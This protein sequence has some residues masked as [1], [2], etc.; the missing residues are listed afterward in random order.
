[1]M[2]IEMAQSAAAG[3]AVRLLLVNNMDCQG[4]LLGIA[5][6]PRARVDAGKASYT[7]YCQLQTTFFSN[8]FKQRPDCE[9]LFPRNDL[10]LPQHPLRQSRMTPPKTP[11]R[12]PTAP[13]PKAP[14]TSRAP[15]E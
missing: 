11:Q 7:G 1:M 15:A 6:G 10:F 4:V 13:R 2:R 3:L 9:Y 12:T 5:G 8:I 14:K